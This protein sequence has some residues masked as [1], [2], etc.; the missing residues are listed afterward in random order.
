MEKVW[1]SSQAVYHWDGQDMVPGPMDVEAFVN[2]PMYFVHASSDNTCKVASTYAYSEARK[3]LG[4]TEDKVLIY[5][6]ED[7]I[8]WG[9]SPMM[10]HFSWVPLLD[11]Y[12]EGSPMDWM[13]KQF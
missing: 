2:L 4:A 10:A 5:S 8:R 1:K 12:S 3:R 7:L 9:V 13:I 11:D 6:D